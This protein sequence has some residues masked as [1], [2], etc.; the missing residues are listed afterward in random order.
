MKRYF[1]I[2]PLVVIPLIFASCGPDYYYETQH[3]KHRTH[4]QH[5]SDDP[6]DFRPVQQF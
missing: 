2:V 4:H 6:R 3:H 1:L 5:R